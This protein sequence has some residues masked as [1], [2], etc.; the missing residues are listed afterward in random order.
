[1]TKRTR[2]EQAP[3]N[4]LHFAFECPRSWDSLSPTEQPSV[5]HCDHCSQL[6]YLCADAEGAKLHGRVGHCVAV[7]RDSPTP[8]KVDAPGGVVGRLLRSRGKES[9][10]VT[11]RTTLG[12]LALP[13]EGGPSLATL[14]WVVPLN[15]PQRGETFQLSEGWAI[16]GSGEGAHIRLQHDESVKPEHCRIV[17]KPRYYFIVDARTD[18]HRVE[19]HDN[20][21]FRVG[22]TSMGF[23]S[24]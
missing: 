2:K 22:K 19:L 14:A 10:T 4:A 11:G 16:I 1:M 17:I 9:T 13:D 20:D 12:M 8:E 6:V 18:D 23:K 5:R 21:V 3:R 24:L 7:L 15:G